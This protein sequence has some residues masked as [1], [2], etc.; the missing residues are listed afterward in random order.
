MAVFQ[1]ARVRIQF[2]QVIWI[3][4]IWT[5]IGWLDSYNTRVITEGTL[6]RPVPDGAF[7]PLYWSQILG[8]FLAGLFSG[9]LLIFVLRDQ[10]RTR[11]FG[12]AL[13]QN[14]LILSL[15]NFFL[16]IIVYQVMYRLRPDPDRILY[17]DQL[18][19]SD[20]YYFRNLVLWSIVAFV[21]IVFLHVNEKYGQG[22]LRK[23]LLGHY[24]K[25]REEERIFMFVDIKSS[26]HI[27][28]MLGHKRFFNFLNDF[29]RDITVP[30]IESAG[31][32]YQ[33]VG[34]EVVVTWPI[35]KGIRNS[36][37]VYCFYRIQAAVAANAPKFKEKYGLSPEF[38]AGLHSG[39]IT[40]G[41]IGIIKKDIVHS[42]D[43]INTT[44]RIQAVCNK[45]RVSILISKRL[46]DQLDL[47]E[48]QFEAK[49]MGIIELKGKK[50]K[51]ELYTFIKSMQPKSTSP[52]SS[53][54]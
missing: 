24:H 37:C 40:T 39:T 12:F 54:T 5:I 20:T 35:E 27:A 33:Y 10:L 45:F 23:M 43:V 3:T 8:A 46:L 25:P 17:R 30:I 16:F 52:Y 19:F 26:T 29:F 2:N 32:I 28:E 13:L 21:T 1:S 22:I 14:S 6:N 48:S 50:E 42:G 9:S 44:S 36:N 38:K 53:A 41:E 51:V 4:I 34:D 49:R 15:L 11:S 7:I 47:P 31:E 18:F